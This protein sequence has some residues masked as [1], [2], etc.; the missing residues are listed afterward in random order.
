MSEDL[1]RWWQRGVI[2]QIYPRSFQDTNGDGI[3]DL[4]GIRRRLDYLQDLGIDAIWMSPMFVSPMKDFGYD[5]ADYCA[6]DP[7]FGTMEDF[8]ALLAD[9]RAR[10]IRVILDL[11]PNHTSDQHAWFQE[12]RTSRESA[13]RDWYLWAD[14]APNGGRPNNWL[15]EFGGPAWTFDEASGQYYYH[16]FLPEQPDLNWRN[17]AVRAA[18][19]DAMR[20]WLR[21]GVAGFRV[22]V[23]WHLLKDE[24]RRD[25]PENPGWKEGMSPT[26]RLLPLY[27]TDLPDV[28]QIVKEM[29]AVVDEFDERVLIGELYLPLER[30]V[31]YYGDQL[32]GAHLPFNFQLIEAPWHA[33]ELDRLVQDYESALPEGGWPNWVLGNHDKPRISGRVGARQARVA[34][35]LLLTLRGTPTL[36]YGDEIGLPQAD[37]SRL[38]VRDPFERNVPG[39]GLGRDGCRTPMQWDDGPQAGF[40]A[41]R[42]WLPLATED[43]SVTVAG[44]ADDPASML[45]LHRRLIAH[46]RGHPALSVGRYRPLAADGDVLLY[47]REHAGERF[48]I[49]LNLGAA[50]AT[51]TIDPP[52][53]GSVVVASDIEREGE[54]ISGPFELGA[55]DGLVVRLAP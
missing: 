48:L 40:S 18:I 41:A 11:V 21:K 16:A 8:D 36:Y 31:R 29:R 2:Y 35:M 52:P 22:D 10:G 25:N 26:H 6:V 4:A 51:I 49:A 46:R 30:L 23:L 37:L 47:N 45:S 13:K 54:A 7:R 24:A 50:P 9:A 33:R 27:T 19:Y 12:A 43:P 28:Q 44:E 14:P 1:P 34:A 39:F 17:P 15:S 38:E 5:V 55:D 3:G 20:F 32:D 42:P 53:S